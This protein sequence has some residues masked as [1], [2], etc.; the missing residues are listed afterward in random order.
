M[1]D[2]E[3]SR[4]VLRLIPMAGLAATAAGDRAA[5]SKI[6]GHKLPEDWFEEAWVAEM[7]LKQWSD[8]PAYG[9]WSIRAIALK[10]TG[11]V[12]GSINS[13]HKPMP[14]LLKG[15]TSLA[16]EVGY[17][18]FAPWRRMGHAI[19]AIRGYGLWAAY[20]GVEAFVLS[21]SPENE[22]S[23]NLAA[24][25]GAIQIGSQIDEKDGPEDIYFA[26]ISGIIT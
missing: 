8:D 12:I 13:H 5:C 22:P 20:A 17:T 24:R 26:K 25:F 1:K 21:I 3:T 11:E 19:E 4:L 2:I 10:R 9:P 23:L 14:F 18:I 15:E 7:R 16:L 6:I